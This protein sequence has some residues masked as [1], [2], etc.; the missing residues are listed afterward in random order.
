[1]HKD[2][3]ETIEDTPQRKWQCTSPWT[4]DQGTGVIHATW[5]GATAG[6]AW[7]RPWGGHDGERRH[8]GRGDG[9]AEGTT[10]AD[11]GTRERGREKL[12]ASAVAGEEGQRGV[13][14]CV[15]AALF[16]R[17]SVGGWGR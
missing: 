6:Q 12:A 4:V 17:G 13:A 7:E 1:M 3:G 16:C 9:E 14:A 2:E 5:G 8:C 15:R 10:E 11:G